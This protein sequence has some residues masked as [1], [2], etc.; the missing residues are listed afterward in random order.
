[1]NKFYRI[2][3]NVIGAVNSLASIVLLFVIC[4]RIINNE[5]LGFDYMGVVVAILA[6]LIT[7]LVAWNIWT[8]I[9]VRRDVDKLR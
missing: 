7:F 4:P 3:I 8:A 5:S 9:G 6:L 1:M 2:F